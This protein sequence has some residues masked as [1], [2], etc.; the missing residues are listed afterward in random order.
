MI[1]VTSGQYVMIGVAI[2][3]VGRA[4]AASLWNRVLFWRFERAYKASVERMR[5]C[6]H[7]AIVWQQVADPK[8]PVWL[9]KCARCWAIESPQLPGSAPLPA[10]GPNQASPKSLAR[11]GLLS[12]TEPVRRVPL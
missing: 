7:D 11:R 6:M 5:G 9:R 4:L 10:W 8:D 2:G 3:S 12:E 1:D